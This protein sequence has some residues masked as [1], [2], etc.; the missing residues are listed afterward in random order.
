M[1]FYPPTT[2]LSYPVVFLLFSRYLH[3]YM[4]W[5]PT[6]LAF[7]KAILPPKI[8]SSP[9]CNLLLRDITISDSGSLIMETLLPELPI[10]YFSL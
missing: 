7:A 9:I 5:L 4:W 3:K 8:V 6:T 2:Y 10:F 1:L